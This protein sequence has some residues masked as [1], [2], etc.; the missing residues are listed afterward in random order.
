M[1]E[2]RGCPLPNYYRIKI[3]WMLNISFK[4]IGCFTKLFLVVSCKMTSFV[5]FNCVVLLV[6]LPWVGLAQ[7]NSTSSPGNKNGTKLNMTTSNRTNALINCTLRIDESAVE[8]ILRFMH[9]YTTHVVKIEVSINSGNKT[10]RFPEL[11]WPWASEIGRT[12]ISLIARY[13]SFVQLRWHF[14]LSPLNG[15]IEKVDVLVSVKNYGC[16][17]AGS[18]GSERV[19]DFLLHQLSLSGDTHNYKLCR[20]FNNEKESVKQYNC[21]RVASGEK[22]TICAKYSSFAVESIQNGVR[23]FVFIILY[24]GFPF[25]ISY[26]RSFPDEREHYGITDSPMALSTILY[27]LFIEGHA[28]GLINTLTTPPPLLI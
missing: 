16:L 22:R 4:L 12:I 28:S 25:I 8:N 17:S 24:I 5:Y 1:G 20:A 21:C 18:K 26:L 7:E 14:P 19:F 11:I 15:G 10:Q 9:N 6:H 27:T 2:Y 23:L 3:I 13:T